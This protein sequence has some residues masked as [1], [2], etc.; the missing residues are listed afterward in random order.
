MTVARLV[1]LISE[2]ARPRPPQQREASLRHPDACRSIGIALRSVGALDEALE[3]F[4]EAARVDPLSP[5]LDYQV[6]VVSYIRGGSEDALALLELALSFPTFA[7]AAELAA[8]CAS[9]MGRRVEAIEYLRDAT[10]RAELAGAPERYVMRLDR[11]LRAMQD[12]DA[13]R[14][15]PVALSVPSEEEIPCSGSRERSVTLGFRSLDEYRG[16][17]ARLAVARFAQSAEPE[18]TARYIAR[19]AQHYAPPELSERA[20][21]RAMAQAGDVWDSMDGGERYQFA[22]LF[23][24]GEWLSGPD[25]TSPVD[26]AALPAAALGLARAAAEVREVNEGLR[27]R[28]S[29]IA[30]GIEGSPRP[31]G[32]SQAWDL[33]A[34]LLGRPGQAGPM[35]AILASPRAG[36]GA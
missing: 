27:E 19:T 5:E 18:F 35:Q 34:E 11:Q 6:A 3:E 32:L 2:G 21:S 36:G 22:G 29:A 33:V 26:A 23:V 8:A 30:A 10:R 20:W 14:I 25:G 16:A 1:R 7:E 31:L 28:L 4:R 17:M 24:L 12:G 13:A 15:E 9:R